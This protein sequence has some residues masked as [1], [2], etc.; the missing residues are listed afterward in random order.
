MRFIDQLAELG[1]CHRAIAWAGNRSLDEAWSTCDR[2]DWMAWLC[3]RVLPATDLRHVLD[4]V[5]L[6]AIIGGANAYAAAY[7]ADGEY[8]AS[9]A[10]RAAMDDD[11]EYAAA[12]SASVCAHATRATRAN[13]TY[14]AYV[15]A[16]ADLAEIIRGNASLDALRSA[17]TT[18]SNQ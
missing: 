9:V 11:G 8:A 2:G 16:N 3:G 15:A 5:V 17:I 12:A 10:F 7:A 13:A 6:Y 1:A 18:R 4:H 14:G